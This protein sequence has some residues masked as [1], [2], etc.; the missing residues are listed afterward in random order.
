MNNQHFFSFVFCQT[1]L[2]GGNIEKLKNQ[3]ISFISNW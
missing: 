3:Q 2:Q 1:D